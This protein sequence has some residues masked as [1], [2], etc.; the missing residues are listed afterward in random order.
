MITSRES[1]SSKTFSRIILNSAVFAG[2]WA[3]ILLATPTA[4]A[5]PSTGARSAEAGLKPSASDADEAGTL[6]ER[7]D[8]QTMKRRYWT[9]GNED[10]MDVVQ[11]RQYTKKGRVETAL[12]YGFWSDDPFQ[13]Q[14]TMAF[15]L[16]YHFNEFLSLHGF[17]GK[18]NASDSAAVKQVHQAT[19][20]SVNPVVNPGNSVMGAELRASLMYGKLSLLGKKIIYYDFNL[21][22]GFSQHK[23]KDGSSSMGF[24]AGLGQQFFLTKTF[25][26]TADYRV[27]WHTDKFNNPPVTERALTT[28]WIQIGVGAFLF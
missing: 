15:S 6:P 25:F 7:I 9:V 20:G 12:R 3:A 26:V 1:L 2:A 13:S 23:T 18:I 5:D 8:V 19:G 10:L 11:N 27:L 24:F 28:N 22:G 17:Y 16:G 14:K 21:A 4:K